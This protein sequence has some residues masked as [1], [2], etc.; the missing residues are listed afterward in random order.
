MPEQQCEPGRTVLHSV[1][2]HVV[3]PIAG[4]YCSHVPAKHTSLLAHVFPHWPQLRGSVLRLKQE[5]PQ[6]LSPV[7]QP[8]ASGVVQAP[9]MHD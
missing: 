3:H 6:E 1:Q 2:G 7:P 8:L 4:A 5:L 9:P